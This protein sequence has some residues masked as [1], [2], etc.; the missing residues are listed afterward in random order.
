MQ[1]ATATSKYPS[2]NQKR[3]FWLQRMA[4]GLRL[5][6]RVLWFCA[7]AVTAS[8]CY[9]LALLRKLPAIASDATNGAVHGA[10]TVAGRPTA[11]RRKVVC[12]GDSITQQGYV[13]I[14]YVCGLCWDCTWM[15]GV[16]LVAGSSWRT[17]GKMCNDMRLLLKTVAITLSFMLDCLQVGG[18]AGRLVDP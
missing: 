16:L 15:T 5:D 8:I 9:Y 13:L 3:T 7:G 2:H 14:G 12:F 18:A 1:K 17:K 10:G 4:R 6:S 11:A